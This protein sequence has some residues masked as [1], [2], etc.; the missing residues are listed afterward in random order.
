MEIPGGIR[1]KENPINITDDWII[2]AGMKADASLSHSSSRTL[3][4][5]ISEEDYAKIQMLADISGKI[6]QDF[7]RE[8]I[9]TGSVTV[10]PNSRV[11][12]FLEQYLYELLG[13]L[14][15]LQSREDFSAELEER[16]DLLLEI[17]S[18]L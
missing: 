2:R 7:I 14:R 3:A 18:R 10:L 6:K 4:F 17:I 15:R 16:M 12:K 13:E 8:R 1:R 11:R 9:L 5:R